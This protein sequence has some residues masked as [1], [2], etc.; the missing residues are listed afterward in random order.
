VH[1][2]DVGVLA[3]VQVGDHFAPEWPVSMTLDFSAEWTLLRR[4]GPF[5]G[6]AGDPLNLEGRVDLGVDGAA[7]AVG[8]G[9]D[10]SGW[11]K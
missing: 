4:C 9:L 3:P 6:D 8:Q 1:Q 7:L 5:E 2:F 10:E 11:P